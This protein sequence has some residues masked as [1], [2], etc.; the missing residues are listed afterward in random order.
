MPD[1]Q[2]VLPPVTVSRRSAR[3]RRRLYLGDAGAGRDVRADTAV[4]GKPAQP[5]VGQS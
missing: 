2:R 4:T 5:Q 3:G 1:C